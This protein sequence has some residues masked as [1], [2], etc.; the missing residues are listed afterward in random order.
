MELNDSGTAALAVTAA[1]KGFAAE[2]EGVT[3]KSRGKE[4]EDRKKR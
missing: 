2:R 4:K 1:A 3:G